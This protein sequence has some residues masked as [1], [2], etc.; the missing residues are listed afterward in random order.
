MSI[1]KMF[2]ND[3]LHLIKKPYKF[4]YIFE[5]TSKN[6]SKFKLLKQKNLKF[7]R[8][9]EQKYIKINKLINY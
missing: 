4:Q 8:K 9:K 5:T 1:N 3:F 6:I 7:R 2:F